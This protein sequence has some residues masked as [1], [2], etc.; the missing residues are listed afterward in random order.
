M[1]DQNKVT[2]ENTISEYGQL[3]DEKNP[4]KFHAQT[5]TICYSTQLTDNTVCSVGT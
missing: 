2:K 4:H 1:N 5:S 3:I